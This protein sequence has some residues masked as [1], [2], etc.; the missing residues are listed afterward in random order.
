MNQ[1]AVDWQRSTAKIA[2]NDWHRARNDEIAS[3]NTI[4][5]HGHN[6]IDSRFFNWQRFGIQ[7]SSLD[8]QRGDISSDLLLLLRLCE[9]LRARRTIGRRS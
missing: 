9:L 1:R 4:A 7:A 3:L 5:C 2:K 6:E 8:W